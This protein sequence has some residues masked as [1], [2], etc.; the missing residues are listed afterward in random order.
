MPDVKHIPSPSELD[1]WI[2][3]PVKALSIST[4]LFLENQHKQ[5]VLSKT[6]Q[7]IIQQFMALD[8][9]YI[10]H[11]SRSHGHGHRQY[12]AYINFLGK[13]LFKADTMSDFVQG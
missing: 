10:L 7:D 2:G 12:C 3:E 9:Q 6:H 4:T 5:P 13:K 8:V 1:R 11:G